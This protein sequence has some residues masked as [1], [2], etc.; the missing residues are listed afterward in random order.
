MAG[1]M[2]K[3]QSQ[4]ETPAAEAQGE[5]TELGKYQD[6]SSGHDI[7]RRGIVLLNILWDQLA[8]LP[9][10]TVPW[11]RGN[12]GHRGWAVPKGSNRRTTLK[13]QRNP[14]AAVF[15]GPT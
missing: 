12:S 13:P 7:W 6:R 4:Q 5:V 9:P 14:G 10:A 11:T 2:G 1:L 3:N 15:P 8:G